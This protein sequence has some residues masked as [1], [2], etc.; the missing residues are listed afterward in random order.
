MCTQTYTHI[1]KE[2]INYSFVQ[3]KNSINH[4]LLPIN[5]VLR[6]YRFCLQYTN[7]YKGKGHP[8]TYLCRHREEAEELLQPIYNLEARR[9]RE[10]STM[11]QPFYPRRDPAPIVQEAG[12]A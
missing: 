5:Q 12:R 1:F 3:F 9:G 10:V 11:P 4:K 7:A 8:M 2:K 6:M